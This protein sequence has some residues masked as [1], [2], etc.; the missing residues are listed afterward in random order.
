MQQTPDHTLSRRRFVKLGG[1][2]TAAFTVGYYFKAL[3]SDAVAEILT[4]EYAEAQGIELT[5]WIT[6]DTKGNITL[7][8]HRSE[9]GQGSF[10][11]VP[12]IIAEELEVDL[13]K[14]K[15]EFARGF[16]GKYGSQVTGGSST[17][18][19]AYKQLLKTG[20]TAREMLMEAAAKRWGVPKTECF[21]E[22]AHIIHRTSGRKLGYGDLVED[23]SKLTPPKE[24]P[25]KAR[26]E[27]KLIGK[28]LPRQ[29][30]PAKING[31][32][33]FGQ[34]FTMPGMLHAMVERNPRFHG[35]VK[36]FDATAALAVPGVKHV[37][38]VEMPVFAFTREG[39]AVV[40]TSTWACL[41]ARK[42]L[43]IEWDDSGFEHL[44][45]EEL[46]K[47]M[48]A[49]LE[50]DGNV[51]KTA[52]NFGQAWS[53]NGTKVEAEYRTP[54]Q[55]HS[56]MEP[57]CCAAYWQPEKIQVW[58]PIQGPDWVQGDLAKT[59]GIKAENVEVNMTFLGGGFGR[60]AFMDYT[61]EAVAISKEIKAPVKVT[62]TREDD[63]T[64]GPFRPGAMYRMNGVLMDGKISAFRTRF[65]GQNMGL[66]DAKE[67]KKDQPNND[68]KEGFVEEYLSSIPTY[69]FSDVPTDVP[70]PVMWWRSVYSSTNAFAYESFM[71]EMAAAAGKDPVAFRKEHLKSDRV[72][73][74]ID[75]LADMSG[76]AKRKKGDGYGIAL[77]ECFGS[78]AGHVVKV[79]KKPG[80]GVQVDKVY[81]AIDCG[82]YVNPDIIRAQVEGSIQMAYGAAVVHETH[83]TDGKAVE[84]NFNEY[85]MPLL[86]DVNHIEVAIMENDEA[87]GGVGEPGLPPFAPALCN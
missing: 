54:Y 57:M 72:K 51:V 71:D 34:D 2:A 16:Q 1:L 69:H 29:D 68:M 31:S 60:K 65:A 48:K 17:I 8:N 43:K 52:G 56:C 49:D 41:Q 64:Q 21:A 62:W 39:V 66:Q 47:R 78:T 70:I 25:L 13:N 82:W 61:T 79:S 55:S 84:K 36:S 67:F 74:L 73:K 87:A 18:R 22:D 9:M 59:F 50:K 3:G 80:G 45:T 75:K 7:Y 14:V 19:S 32:A 58:G 15:I 63:M 5:A 4:G 11:S 46:F 42:V 86:G 81:A 76:W 12:Q 77:T 33:I 44:G 23:A 53:G 35:R 38:K 28:P 27:Y 30:N 37:F 85:N 40:A 83:F 24:V 10:Q 6:I 20:A 26:K